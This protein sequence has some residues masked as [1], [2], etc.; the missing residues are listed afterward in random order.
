MPI[1]QKPLNPEWEAE[2]KEQETQAAVDLVQDL[3]FM[4]TQT[5][6]Q[7]INQG[8]GGIPGGD[9]KDEMILNHMRFRFAQANLRAKKHL[10]RY[11]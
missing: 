3:R 7:L 4:D 5:L 8:Y 2:F 6:E 1:S 10:A 9:T 11:N